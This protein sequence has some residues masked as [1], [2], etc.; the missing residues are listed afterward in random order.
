MLKTVAQATTSRQ[1]ITQPSTLIGT[2]F[3]AW[4]IAKVAVVRAVVRCLLVGGCRWGGGGWG[5]LTGVW[6]DVRIPR[7]RERHPTITHTRPMGPDRDEQKPKRQPPQPQ[8]HPRRRDFADLGRQVPII[9]KILR[10]DPRQN[11][12]HIHHSSDRETRRTDANKHPG[13]QALARELVRHEAVDEGGVDHEG[14][15][16]AYPLEDPAGDDH[17]QGAHA[18]DV[19]CE[20]AGVGADYEERVGREDPDGGHLGDCEGLG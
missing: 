17:V 8:P 2:L 16:E 4:P 15:E 19:G 6:E 11:L 1:A 3:R 10:N 13:P 7:H 20:D 5:V 12:A 9:H 18:V 14:D